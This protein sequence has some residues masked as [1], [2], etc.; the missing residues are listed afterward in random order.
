MMEQMVECLLPKVREFHKEMLAEI[1]ASKEL[2]TS[3]KGIK[4][5]P[6][7]MKAIL[8]EM[9]TVVETGLEEVKAMDYRP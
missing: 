1:K 5:C 2:K 3:R 9:K 7:K 4:P 6:D 8:E